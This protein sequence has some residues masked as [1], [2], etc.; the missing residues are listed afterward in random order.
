MM[1][2]GLG[3]AL[4]LP[5]ASWAAQSFPAFLAQLQ[6]RARAE[7]IPA[8]VVEA[9]TAHLTPNQKVLKLDHHQPEFTL[10]WAKYSSI[11]LTQERIGTGQ[12]TYHATQPL[13][14]AVTSRYGVSSQI[15]LG[16]WGLET[17]FGSNQGDFNVIDAL[18]TLSWDRQSRYFG[19]E[20]IDAMKIVAQGDAPV[21]RLLGS[22]AGAM[23]QPQFM[24]STY[25]STAVSFTGHGAPDIWHSNADA[26]ASMANYL[27]KAG[28]RSDE[29]SSESVAVPHGVNLGE[30][31]RKHVRTLGY[32]ERLGVQRLPGAVRLPDSMPA[33]LLLPDGP[34]GQAF[35]VY[36]NF[37]V[38]RRYN[39]SDYYALA[40]GAL[41]RMI[42]A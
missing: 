13:L 15:I 33:A 31:G 19:N 36:Q 40:V 4:A 10:T 25:L 29:P 21:S 9:S 26:L 39:P 34:G 11:V 17:N 27:A 28:W 14:A 35:L 22:Y 18:A 2:A 24:P 38:I 23:G 3:G 42:L 6:A 41:G 20:A 5:K 32:W 16:I 30:T 7:G 1:L 37:S 8:R 12:K